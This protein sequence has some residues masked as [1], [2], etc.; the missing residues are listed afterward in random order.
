VGDRYVLEEMLAGGYNLG[1][2]QSGHIIMLDMNTTGDGL[3]TALQLMSIF[4]TQNKPLSELASIFT[5]YPQVLVNCRVERKEGLETNER[6][7]EA[8]NRV[9]KDLAGRGRLLVRPS[10]TEHLV[11]VMMEGP[12]EAELHTMAEG[13]AEIIRQE[14]T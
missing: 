14:L 3:L 9:E 6:I 4:A 7:R 12:N 2:E 8:V 1:G 11:R 10:G 13:L 5:R